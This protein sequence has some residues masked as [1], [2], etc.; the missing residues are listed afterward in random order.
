MCCI[1]STCDNVGDFGRASHWCAVMREV[2]ERWRG[3]QMLGVCRA[4]YGRV[5]ATR[6]EWEQAEQEL[7]LALVDFEASR[8]P[9]GPIGMVRLG[10]LRVR[11]GRV[12]EARDLFERAGPAGLVGLGEVALAEDDAVGAAELAER[13]LRRLPRTSLL[14][15]IPPLELLARARATLGERDAAEAALAELAETVR[16]YP[17]PYVTG[18]SR[19][20]AAAVAYAT[21][22]NEAARLAWEDAIDCSEE[23]S[24][25]YDA[26]RARLGLAETLAAQGRGEHARSLAQAAREAFERLGASGDAERAAAVARG[27]QGG[28]LSELTARELEVLRLVAAGLSD[29]EIAERLVVSPHTVHRHVANIRTKLRLP[30]RAAAVAYAAREGL[31]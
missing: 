19:M 30:S 1:V 27:P 21:G 29:A 17:T 14:D 10:E 25:P 18:R 5:L 9:L 8:P 3:R 16:P 26:A 4:S 7:T 6:G 12:E 15:R 31:I 2:A 11:Q 13:A 23:G 22:D 20:A 24:A 28:R